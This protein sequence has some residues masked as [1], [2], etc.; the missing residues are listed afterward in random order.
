[1]RREAA[2]LGGGV[3]R[4]GREGKV[5]WGDGVGGAMGRAH[6]VGGAMGWWGGVAD[7]CRPRRKPS[8]DCPAEQPRSRRSHAV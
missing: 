5:R 4:V 3:E 1:M 2:A 7:D 6:V 8:F